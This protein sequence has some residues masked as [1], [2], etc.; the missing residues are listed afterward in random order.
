MSRRPNTRTSRLVRTVGMASLVV[1]CQFQSHRM[2]TSAMLASPEPF[3]E[4]QPN[5]QVVQLQLHGDTYDSWM[6]D[7]D[8]YTVLRDPSSGSFFYAEDDGH[9]GLQPSGHLVFPN[10]DNHNRNLQQRH[11]RP[12]K[13]DCQG[14]ICGDDDDDQRNTVGGGGGTKHRSDRRSLRGKQIVKDSKTI[15]DEIIAKSKHRFNMTNTSSSPLVDPNGRRLRSIGTLRNLVVLIR[16]SDHQNRVLPSKENIDILMNH[17]GPHPLC[18]TGSV[19]DVYLENSYGAL[20]LQSTVTD[21][22][23]INNTESYFANGNSGRSQ[24]IREAI[25]YALEYLDK[26][27]LVDFDYFDEDQDGY[28]DSIT[29]LH[30]GYG[31]EFGGTDQFGTFYTNRIWSHKW[32]LYDIPFVTQS[33]VEVLEY[34][35]SP[36]LWH[37]VGVSIGRIGVI[38]HETGHFLGVP[39]M[40]DIDGGGVGLGTFD[41][42]ANSWGFDGSQYFP[43]HMSAW[44]KLLL[45][46]MIPYFPSPGVNR[47]AA[48]ELQDA[49]HP[50]VFVITEGFPTGEFLLVE[51]RQKLGF[52]SIMP[53][54]GIIIY[55]IDHGSST[56]MFYESL[57]REGHPGQADW[58]ENGNHY[59]VAVVQADGLYQLERGINA[60]DAWDF[61]HSDGIDSLVPCRD[62]TACQYPNTDSYQQGIVARTNVHITDISISGEEMTFKYRVG[63]FETEEPTPAPSMEPSVHPSLGPSEQPTR[64]LG[65][66]QRC[67]AHDNCCS[68]FCMYRKKRFL[69]MC[70]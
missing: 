19:R 2:T 67:L 25:R 39:D 45:G 14:M 54:D 35:I 15:V 5:G 6:T 69:G 33:G 55:H 36:S 60:G 11:L 50:Q 48:A 7:M 26:N 63:D 44:T 31:A 64:C 23:P 62:P 56:A 43:P 8:G 13:R 3:F 68:G 24:R 20:D 42:M 46:W 28:M 49:T 40:Y 12:S 52:D 9:G 4:E 21:W 57:R 70:R 10:P 32:G 18:P 53:Q 59:G 65:T 58:P 66:G 37:R 27:D 29:F 61:Y 38:A 1:L 47:V 17:Q 34:H 41:M 51:N 16:W 22:I 30:S